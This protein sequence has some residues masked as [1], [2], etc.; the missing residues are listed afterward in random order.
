[1]RKQACEVRV[2]MTQAAQQFIT[3]LTC[4]SLSGHAVASD[5]FDPGQELLMGHIELARWAD[6][7]LIAPASA[8]FLA[9]M[10]H[11]LAD[12]LL[13][14]LVLAAECPISVAP[15]M[16]QAMW[17]NPATQY[18]LELLRSRNVAIIGPE[19]GIQACGE[20]G[21]GRMSEPSDIVQSLQLGWQQGAEAL[22]GLRVLISAG[23][24]REAIDPVRYISNRSSG[25]MG[26]AL[27]KAAQQRGAQVTLVS[28]PVNLQPPIGCRT[29]MVESA[30]EMRDAILLHA[31]QADV[32]IGAAAVAD[33]RIA[34]RSERKIKKSAA[35]TLE[36]MQNPDII[37]EVAALSSK[38]FVVGFAAETDD[39]ESYALGKLRAKN[40]D[41]IAANWV[42]G[43]HGGFDSE[44]NALQVFWHDGRQHL[45]MTDKFVLAQQLLTL[46]AQHWHDQYSTQNS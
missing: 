33:Y 5:L 4:Q 42:G 29:I 19:S 13:S 31:S 22:T 46:I 38:P 23:P 15:A 16:N 8:D 24:T 34:K 27:A 26:Y 37:T 43:N 41:M 44:Q 20:T 25:K 17:R 9:K 35:I 3:P 40:L 32:Y 1:L 39:L 14:A 21:L 11:G 6:R 30:L 7:I 2:V 18:N 36:L 28:G 45:P 10:A 12:D